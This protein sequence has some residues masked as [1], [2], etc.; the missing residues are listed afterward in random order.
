MD[1][2]TALRDLGVA[3]DTLTPAERDRLD[4]HGFLPLEGILSTEQVATFNARLAELTAAEGDR[5][6]LE[7]H[8]ERGAERLADLVNKDP[9]FDVCFSHP[10]VLAAMR[11]VL[12]SFRLYSLNARAALPGQGHQG[13]HADYAAPVAAGEYLVCNSIWLLD[14]FTA[15]NGATRIVPG[16][17]RSGRLPGEVMPD[18]TAAHPDEVSLLAPAG[19]VVIF[20][21]HLWHGGT[22]NRTDRPRRALHSC[23]ADRDLPQQLD[24]QA[25]VRVN[26][27]ARLTPAQRFILDVALPGA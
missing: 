8:Q 19:T 5:A 25:Y 22:L 14:D 2:E 26:T 6:G 15:D 16:T 27:Y 13:L 18:P 23:F 17:H 21:S 9:M 7:V 4:R 3:D 11:H 20:N 12:G 24:Q 1:M 10:R